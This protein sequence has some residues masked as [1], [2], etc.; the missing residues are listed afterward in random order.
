MRSFNRRSAPGVK[1]GRVQK[2][3]NWDWTPKYWSAE[4]PRPVIDRKRWGT[5][6]TG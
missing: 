2:K 3:N 5:T 4:Q 6:T 1:A